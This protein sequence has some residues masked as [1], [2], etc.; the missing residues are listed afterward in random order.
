M[1]DHMIVK[2][3]SS[4]HYSISSQGPSSLSGALQSQ[5]LL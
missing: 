2:N 5:Q 4:G 1:K 3:N